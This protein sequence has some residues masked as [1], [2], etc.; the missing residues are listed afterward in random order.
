MTTFAFLPNI[1]MTELIVLAVLGLLI[2]GR[3][4]PEVGRDP[5]PRRSGSRRPCSRVDRPA[6]G[7]LGNTRPPSRVLARREPPGS[8]PDVQ[9]PISPR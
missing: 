5:L 9:A 2:F 3:R 8:K 7:A 4:L 6:D 1:G